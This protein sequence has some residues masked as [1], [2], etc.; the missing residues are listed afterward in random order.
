MIPLFILGVLLTSRRNGPFLY[1][2]P[3][4]GHLEQPMKF[5]EKGKEEIRKILTECLVLLFVL[6]IGGYPGT[7]GS[8]FWCFGIHSL[9]AGPDPGRAD[10]LWANQ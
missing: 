7:P 10:L 5:V 2:L 3:C 1:S 9:A 8:S 6:L 4:G